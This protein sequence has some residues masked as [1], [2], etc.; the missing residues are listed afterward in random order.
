MRGMLDAPPVGGRFERIRL[1]GQGGMGRIYEAR[2]LWLGGRVALKVPHKST[3]EDVELRFLRE[4]EALSRIEHPSI[5]RHVAHGKTE[6]GD[7]FLAMEWV[8]GDTLRERLRKAQLTISESVTLAFKVA[9]ALGAIH[10]AG[11]VHRDIKPSNILLAGGQLQ[12]PVIVDFGLARLPGAGRVTI[13]GAALGTPGYMAPEQ[14]RGDPDVD[15]RADLFSFG[16]VLFR[17]LTGVEAFSGEEPLQLLLQLVLTDPP[18]VSSLRADVPASLDA[19]VARLLSKSRE[20][21]PA[22]G[23]EAAALL[24]RFRNAAA[25]G[26]ISSSIFPPSS[27]QITSSERRVTALVLM[28]DR[29]LDSDITR[30]DPAIRTTPRAS[31]AERS[32]TAQAIARRHQGRV[33]ALADDALLVVL[34]SAA[35]PTDLAARAARCALSLRAEMGDLP[36]AV[37]TG[38]AEVEGKL[39]VGELITHAIAL[40]N[41]SCT[42]SN[43]SCI[44]IDEATSRLAGGRFEAI[45]T[46]LGRELC[47]ERQEEQVSL[48]LGKPTVCVGRERELSLLEGAAI[49]CFEESTPA[50]MVITGRPGTGKSRLRKE[51]CR[52]LVTQGIPH[53]VWVGHAD[54][55]CAGAAFG[56]LSSAIRHGLG[57]RE[58]IDAD[59]RRAQ[60]EAA[61][62]DLPDGDRLALFLGELLGAHAPA[63]DHPQLRAAR[64]D[65]VLLGDQIRR[66]A[67]E[68]LRARCEQ[69]LI[70]LILE[71]LQWGD[72]P[73]VT[74]VSSVLR[75]LSAL[76]LFVL[77]L[78]RPEI[79]D[80]FPKLWEDRPHQVLQLG[81][82]PKRAAERFLT[83]ALGPLPPL[84]V[85]EF[86]EHADGNPF[87][88][89]ELV[90]TFAAGHT[91]RLPG[92]VVAMAQARVATLGA[93]AR[94]ILRAA[95]VFGR[96]FFLPGVEALL[97][98]EDAAIHIADLVEA[99]V[100][101]RG[102]ERRG[103]RKG[104]F[105]EDPSPANGDIELHFGHALLREA[106]YEM[107]TEEDRKVGHLL[108]AEWL[109]QTGKGD[110][111][112]LAEHFERGGAKERAVP[113]H[114][115]AAEDALAGND[116]AAAITRAER[117]IA[118]GA[119]GEVRGALRR[120][121][122]EAHVWRSELAEAA[123]CAEEAGAE[124]PKGG[125]RWYRALTP[126]V[127]AASACGDMA[128]V[129]RW[130]AEA[131]NASCAKG[132]ES[133]FIC[134]LTAA[135]AVL[136]EV[137]Q[138]ARADSLL[139][140]ASALASGPHVADEQ[141]L[142]LIA[143]TRAIQAIHTADLAG[144]LAPLEQA[145]R[146]F[147]G[148][149]DL[150]H[151]CA[152]R[153]NNGYLRTE[154]GDFEEAERMLCAALADAE[155]LGLRQ[156]VADI[157]SNLG[158]LL[159]QA[160][161][162][163]EAWEHEERAVRMAQELGQLRTEGISRS[164]LARIA[165][166]NGDP[167][168]AEDHARAAIAL[169]DTAPPLRPTAQAVLARALL[170]QHRTQEAFRSA[171]EAFEY[172]TVRGN[173]EE[174]EALVRLVFADALRAVGHRERADQ[175]FGEARRHLLFRAGRIQDTRLRDSFL[176]RVPEHAATL[177]RQQAG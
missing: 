61:V 10:A 138:T 23:N 137:G 152:A 18:R 54:P 82:L 8:E 169:L 75:S 143:Q 21:R 43:K 157:H 134:F 96:T 136:C 17:C 120:A 67:A 36:M 97:G 84:Q 128:P 53:E 116:L 50:L 24:G 69:G 34:S 13:T 37:A 4:A 145:L 64:R 70:L 126:M 6:N 114:L 112:A 129:E 40:L 127:Y 68:L 148:A 77:A 52:R 161:R 9:E 166:L 86:L 113:W 172:L 159:C 132:A 156:L 11:M 63:E 12:S 158:Y 31:D 32:E 101:V 149:G 16:C 35:A 28:R 15:A 147:L 92:T 33:E 105:S 78:G 5:A 27:R 19:L 140:T 146:A 22:N 7:L 115:L 133:A 98:G 73:T 51:L 3:R 39:S 170:A 60:L 174:G 175:A 177:D 66:A 173:V 107:L 122:A 71:D 125:E 108:A 109:E 131:K 46:P 153:M 14:A 130:L 123:R 20:S 41:T 55:L 83:S 76:P 176:T 118:C 48:L 44:L 168:L 25:T 58:D 119:E 155:R 88:L 100:L 121:Q 26:P 62:R 30:I 90:R 141:A 81:G 87:Y 1:A 93:P 102:G 42:S 94:R 139:A 165:L 29:P 135:A 171:Q 79:Q 95:S 151:G 49:A 154:L 167:G 163:T 91:E 72:L 104:S 74:F 45:E 164:Y 59:A 47:G 150:R 162:G 144:A 85:A 110:P 2:D 124:L 106:A 57:I 89:E 99:E 111:A 103:Y 65:P 117:G 56:V 142:G 160:G 80:V 38:W